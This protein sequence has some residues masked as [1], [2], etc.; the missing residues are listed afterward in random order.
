MP[1]GLKRDVVELADHDPEWEDIA[2]E[3]VGRLWRIFG[4]A[5]RDI[6][7]IGST[8]IRCI[9][10]KPIIDIAVAVEDGA[11]V[12]KLIPA[13]EAG[14]FLYR[15]RKTEE[16][17]LFAVGDDAMPDGVQT[18]FIHV[19]KMDSIDWRNCIIFRDY[20]NAN[21]AVAKAYLE[22]VGVA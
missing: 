17:M 6:Q 4:A 18:H 13:L 5:A 14:G 10:A 9:K 1:I 11:A 7:H 3:T 20:L 16:H 19:M 8:A 15:H 21:L 12:A 2:R 22:S